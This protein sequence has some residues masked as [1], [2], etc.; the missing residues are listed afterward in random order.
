MFVRNELSFFV[1]GMCCDYVFLYFFWVGF[2]RLSWFFIMVYDGREGLGLGV[3]RY[4]MVFGV[5]YS[6][7]YIVGVV[8]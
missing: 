1:V 5:R 3:R 4:I 7:R 2:I 8:S 6:F